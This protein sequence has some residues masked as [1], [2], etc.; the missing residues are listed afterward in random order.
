MIRQPKARINDQGQFEIHHSNG[1][2]ERFT[3]EE[4]GQKRWKDVLADHEAVVYCLNHMAQGIQAGKNW[5]K[6]FTKKPEP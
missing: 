1:M 5:E 2:V 3:S 4:E 6:S